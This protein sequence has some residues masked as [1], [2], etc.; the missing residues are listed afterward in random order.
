M[1]TEPDE[2]LAERRLHPAAIALEAA[3]SVRN[4][5]LPIFALVVFGA[6]SGNP[7]SGLALAV[8]GLV[9]AIAMGI[10]RWATTIYRIGPDR[11]TLRSGLISPDE[12]LVPR[13]RISSV[14]VVAGPLQ[15]A[16]GV[17]ELHVQAAGGGGEAEIVLR[18]LDGEQARI[19]REQL[20]HPQDEVEPDA[21]WRLSPRALV[22][23]ALT[24]PQAGV[25]VPLAAGVGALLQDV[26]QAGR[27]DDVRDL[28]P[29][30][31][32][33]IVL[34]SVLV[35]VVL[36][37]IAVAGALLAFGGFE[38]RREGRLLRVRRGL[39]E[40]RAV[41]IPLARVHAVRIV[42][43]PVRQLFGLASVHI[44]T[45]AHGSEHAVART[46]L[47][48][49]RRSA[50]PA[51][52]AELLPSLSL[53]PE[54][55]EPPPARSRRR[56][57]TVPVCAGLLTGGVLALAD[58]GLWPA[59]PALALAGGVLG[60]LRFRDAGWAWTAATSRSAGAPSRARRSSRGPRGSS[61]L[62]CSANPFQR[63]AGLA[64]AGFAVGAGRSAHVAH[65][66]AGVASSLLERL[67]VAAVT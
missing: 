43:N 54:P 21:E 58:G 45:V 57:A 17:V 51:L 18:A 20:G 49:A 5:L 19:V 66:D 42:E 8:V 63:R 2:P 48:I 35:A 39:L 16:L 29:G 7:F 15:R 53:P 55:L 6:Q 40:R 37:L 24:A 64:T 52:L 67:R 59:I 4:L 1:T 50:L 9:S 44:E 28:V 60:A 3:S 36:V 65:L 23:A 61:G 46:L 32:G 11:I 47:P 22:A 12:R 27:T 33:A 26:Q 13:A 56:Y 31:T 62:S 38:V 25:L 41:T 10:V 14:D 30:S 34:A